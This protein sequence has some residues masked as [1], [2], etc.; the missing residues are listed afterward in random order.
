M[1]TITPLAGQTTTTTQTPKIDTPGTDTIVKTRSTETIAPEQNA[2][3]AVQESEETE[4]TQ[5]GGEEEESPDTPE[6]DSTFI[7][8]A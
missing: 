8:T 3:D 7:A 5:G 2:A 4:S 6:K 1:A